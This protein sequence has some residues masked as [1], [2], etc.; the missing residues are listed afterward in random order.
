MLRKALLTTILLMLLAVIAASTASHAAT[1]QSRQLWDKDFAYIDK[2][3]TSCRL[4]TT[5][6]AVSIGVTIPTAS[7]VTSTLAT[8][9]S[10]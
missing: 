8:A 2:I 9:L 1:C 6:A 3:S 4:A 7:T 5:A 10:D